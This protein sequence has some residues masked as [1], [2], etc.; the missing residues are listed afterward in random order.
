MVGEAFY[1]YFKAVGEFGTVATCTRKGTRASL[2]R[3]NERAS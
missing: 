1:S 3:N 2:D